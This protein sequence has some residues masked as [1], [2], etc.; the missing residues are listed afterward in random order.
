VPTRPPEPPGPTTPGAVATVTITPAS[1]SLLVGQTTTLVATPKDAAGVAL[2]GRTVTWASADSTRATVSTAGVVTARDT[3]VARI[4]ASV[5]GKQDSAT[6]TVHIVPVA[7]VAI[8]PRDVTLHVGD[9]LRLTATSLDSAGHPLTGRS[10]LWSSSAPAKASVSAAGL[11]S[12]LD[13]GLALIRASV[14]GKQDSTTFTMRIVAVAA[15][16]VAPGGDTLSVGDTLRLNATV[17]DSAGRPLTG[18]TVFWASSDPNRATVSATGLVTVRDT[19]AVQ[20]T[21]TSEARSATSTLLLPACASLLTAVANHVNLRIGAGVLPSGSNSSGAGSFRG[22]EILLA[23]GVIYGTSG[24]NLVLGYDPTSGRSDLAP[25]RVCRLPPPPGV[26][27]HA[28]AKLSVAPGDIGPAGITVRQDA[29]VIGARDDFV[30]MRYT[31][32][33]TSQG[34]ITNLAAGLVA[35][36]R[37]HFDTSGTPDRLRYDAG[38]VA[39]EAVDRDTFP[40]PQIAAAMPIVAAGGGSLSFKAWVDGADPVGRSGFF[41]ALTGGIDASRTGQPGDVRG[42]TG[43]RGVSLN[44]GQQLVLYIV[45]L[46]DD[47][48]SEFDVTAADARAA[49]ASLP[50]GP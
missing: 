19:G 25:S 39:Q 46:A 29:F 5:E 37:I 18:R 33:N 40:N 26:G 10:V 48:R 24:S 32:T 50:G 35:D 22:D 8:A 14:E 17:L 16:A 41:A 23:G 2:T 42:L 11:V 6:I 13:T 45:L 43:V 44:P 12:A 31:F 15:V 9:T 36:W 38:Q 47:N 27:G 20:I 30:L 4:R 7:G 28:Y 49:V 21:A 3:G 1:A 34:V